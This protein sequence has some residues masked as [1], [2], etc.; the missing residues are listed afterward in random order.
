MFLVLALDLVAGA[1]A[2]RVAPLPQLQ[3]AASRAGVV[4]MADRWQDAPIF[5]ESGPDPIFDDKQGYLGKVPYGFSNNAE[6]INGRAAMM[7]FSVAYVQEAIT[8][9]GVLEQYGLPYDE[10]SP[11]GSNLP[12]FTTLW[13]VADARR[14]ADAASSSPAPQGA[15]VEASGGNIFAAAFGLVFAVALVTGLT[16][17]GS[18]L[19]SKIDKD[20]DG[21]S[22]PGL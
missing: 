8:G 3:L 13:S 10:A 17:G 4:A 6:I 5:D 11:T 16:Y 1:G 2:M 7:G 22:L 12:R 18:I 15:V 14:V 19:Y 20:Y 9:K 21:T